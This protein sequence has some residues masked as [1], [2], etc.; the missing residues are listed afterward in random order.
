MEP[1]EWEGFRRFPLPPSPRTLVKGL[2][3]RRFP[4][5]PSP[6][7][8]VKGLEDGTS[9]DWKKDRWYMQ[10]K[11]KDLEDRNHRDN[12]RFSGSLAMLEGND[13]ISILICF[14]PENTKLAFMKFY[15]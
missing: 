14:V 9:F 2:G 5:P 13:M 1:A 6:R 15:S 11:T 8:L 4:L 3:F 10:K 12:L 7:T